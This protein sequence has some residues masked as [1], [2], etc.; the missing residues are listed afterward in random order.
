M[1]KYEPIYQMNPFDQQKPKNHF[2]KKKK[3]KKKQ[4]EKN[5][6]DDREA[7]I[8]EK[9]KKNLDHFSIYACHPCAGAMLIFSVSFQFYR[10]SRRTNSSVLLCIINL[11]LLF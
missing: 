8:C 4:T 9:E 1:I 7:Q 3:K 11:S 6:E 10:M 5:E 2:I